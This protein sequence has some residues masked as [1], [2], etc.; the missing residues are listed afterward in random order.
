M[1]EYLIREIVRLARQFDR[2]K[3]YLWTPEQI[4][5]VITQA[6]HTLHTKQE[7]KEHHAHAKSSR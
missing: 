4:V 1:D 7:R 6:K 3:H 2:S 5:D